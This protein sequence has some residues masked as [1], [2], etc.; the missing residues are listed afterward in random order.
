MS[1]DH[2]QKRAGRGQLPDRKSIVRERKF[3]KKRRRKRRRQRMLRLTAVIAV[4]I[5]SA[6]CVKSILF[7]NLLNPD[8][9][10]S[11]SRMADGICTGG[12]SREGSVNE[13]VTGDDVQ[14]RLE[15]MA[16]TDPRINEI[17]ND[18]EQYPQEMRELLANNEET[19]DFVLDYPSK[20]DASPA[21]SIR[22][23]NTEWPGTGEIPLLLQWDERWGYASYGGSVIAVSGC[24]PTV[25]SMVASG[26]TGDDSITPYKVARYAEENGYYYPGEGT[27]W[28]LMTEGATRFGI[29]GTEMGLDQN[30]I[31][32][33][34]ESGHPI[35]C[36]MRPGDFTSTG[37]FIVLTGV[38]DGMIRVNDP[39][40]R[41]NS[42]KLWEYDR[43]EYQIN[44]LWAF[45]KI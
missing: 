30:V 13:H 4:L 43:I 24:G 34:L 37:H 31:Y 17:L 23:D 39:N 15:E 9:A 26:L 41:I 5:V 35:I 1:G 3:Q 7:D 45:K 27:A 36:S 11:I 44:N 25:I 18:P 20:K 28:T 10:F 38:E 21:E 29:R 8:S 2:K 12:N 32:S 40:S 19:I 6:G 33:E 42:E 22:G 16:Q 14:K